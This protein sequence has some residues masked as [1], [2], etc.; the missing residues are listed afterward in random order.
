MDGGSAPRPRPGGAGPVVAPAAAGTEVAP[1]RRRV[2]S[3]SWKTDGPR[4]RMLAS[5]PATLSDAELV[6]LVLGTGS[7]HLSA[8]AAALSLVERSPVPELA[9]APLR[10]CSPSIPGSG[11]HAPRRSP[12][13]SS[14]GAAAPGPRRAGATASSSPRGWRE[15][16]RHAA[17]AERECFHVVMLDVRGTAHPG[18]AGGR[19]VAHPVPGLA[20]RC[21]P[22]GGAGGRPRGD[23]RAQPPVG[24]SVAVR[25]RTPTSP[26]GC[27]PP[28]S[29]WG[30]GPRPRHRGGG[31]LLQLRRGGAVEEVRGLPSGSGR[32]SY[33]YW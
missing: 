8:R 28:P 30:A 23:L 22:T 16:M 9:W 14:W 5:G 19:G 4:E 27:A 17:H 11:R 12:P 7:G 20:A 3:G 15:L 6:A 21:A 33:S 13:P 1:A 24:R 2:H 32:G 31:R 26:S 29:W 10:R 25:R 18:G